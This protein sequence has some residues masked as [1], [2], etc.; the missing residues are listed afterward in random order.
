MG[1]KQ[2]WRE[3][4]PARKTDFSQAARQ[5]LIPGQ[6]DKGFVYAGVLSLIARGNETAI[7]LLVELGSEGRSRFCSRNRCAGHASELL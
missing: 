7:L 6:S 1:S 3:S 5:F 4:R 2:I